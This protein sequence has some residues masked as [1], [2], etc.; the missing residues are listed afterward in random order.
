[1]E[2]VIRLCTYKIAPAWAYL[3]LSVLASKA[4]IIRI[5]RQCGDFK[6]LQ[7]RNRAKPIVQK[8]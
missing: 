5:Q 3:E 4:V 6:L 7:D 1:M 2:P 8:R